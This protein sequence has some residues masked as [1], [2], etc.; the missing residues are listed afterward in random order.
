MVNIGGKVS[1]KDLFFSA[2]AAIFEAQKVDVHRLSLNKCK[3]FLAVFSFVAG[4]I[5][6]LS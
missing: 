3:F 1:A 6:A 5:F 4:K 2:K